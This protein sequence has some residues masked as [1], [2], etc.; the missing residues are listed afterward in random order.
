MTQFERYQ[1][2][3]MLDHNHSIKEM[4]D[5]LSKYQ[6]C[7]EEN[8]DIKSVFSEWEISSGFLSEIWACE[9]EWS[10][11]DKTENETVAQVIFGEEDIRLRL[12]ELGFEEN[13]ELFSLVKRK[14]QHHIFEDL[15]IETGW[16]V[17]TSHI[18][19]AAR[20]LGI[21]EAN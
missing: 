18:Y 13:E 11:F 21:K 10:E 12:E 4:I 14:C 17:M 20:E 7:C 1:L 16:D 15:M 3:W 19:D 9:A 8:A 5:E 6:K 2:Q